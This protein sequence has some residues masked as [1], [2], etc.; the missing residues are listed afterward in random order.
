MGAKKHLAGTNYDSFT[1]E[2]DVVS[3][4]HQ[5]HV[6]SLT[7]TVRERMENK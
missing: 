6:L 3:S 7:A 5:V 2:K 4:F 1:T